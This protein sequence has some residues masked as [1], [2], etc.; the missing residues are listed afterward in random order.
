MQ[1][2]GDHK[3]SG[4]YDREELLTIGGYSISQISAASAEF[5]A[6]DQ[7]WTSQTPSN[8][9]WLPKTFYFLFLDNYSILS[10][11]H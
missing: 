11:I 9:Q 2:F 7:T 3:N 4:L 6:S 10:F 5:Q 8:E 1:C